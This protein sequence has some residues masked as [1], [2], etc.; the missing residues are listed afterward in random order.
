MAVIIEAIGLEHLGQHPRRP[1]R[2]DR[3]LPAHGAVTAG[4]AFELHGGRAFGLQQRFGHDPP[5]VEVMRTEGAAADGNALGDQQLVATADDHLRGATADIH[6]QPRGLRRQGVGH[7]GVDQLRLFVTGNDVDAKA[8]VAF[9]TGQEQRRVVRFA[10]RAGGHRPHAPGLET[11]QLFAESR[12]RLPATVQRQLIERPALQAFGQTH[13]FTQGFHFLDD[14]L[15]VPSHRLANHQAKRIGAQVDGGKQ[16]GVFHRGFLAHS[17]AG[18]L[19][20]VGHSR[21][22]ARILPLLR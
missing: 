11:T 22:I 19:A 21:R 17:S 8:Q 18:G 10:Y 12:Q 6:H 16:R 15:L 7:A 1:G 5:A 9:G 2:A 14:H 13:W 20:A 4:N 3:L